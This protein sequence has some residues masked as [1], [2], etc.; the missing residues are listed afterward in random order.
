MDSP[1]NASDEPDE[2]G[3][4]MA[5]LAGSRTTIE[6][7][8]T[9]G[10]GLTTQQTCC[11]E[12]TGPG[13]Y[14]GEQVESGCAENIQDHQDVAEGTHHCHCHCLVGASSSL[15]HRHRRPWAIC[16]MEALSVLADRPC[17]IV[18]VVIIGPH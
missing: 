11:V 13:G 1:R 14:L 9:T 4:E 6:A 18:V 16:P 8:R 12:K 7:P 5:A 15:P 10:S 17:H 3:S 2:P